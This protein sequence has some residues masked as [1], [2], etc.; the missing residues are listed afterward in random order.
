[1][2]VQTMGFVTLNY[3]VTLNEAPT[4]Q[5]QEIEIAKST[6]WMGVPL[7]NRQSR[8]SGYIGEG[9]SKQVIYV[10]NYILYCYQTTI[11]INLHG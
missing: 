4:N 2:F 5:A 3:D 9:S 6:T 11:T 10:S 7:K 1:M 8:L